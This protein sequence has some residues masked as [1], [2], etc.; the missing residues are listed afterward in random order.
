MTSHRKHH[1]PK[2]PEKEAGPAPEAP[3]PEGRVETVEI[4]KKELE[5]L[6]TLAG[7]D[8]EYR[9]R[10]LRTL[11][12]MENLRKRLERE[13]KEYIEYANQELMGEFIP[14]LDNFYRALQSIPASEA[15]APLRE[16]VKMIFR[17]LED[18]LRKQ[19]L[20]EIEAEGKTFNPH[21]H[22]AV[23]VEET[24]RCP[25]DTVLEVI[26]KGYLFRG[27]LLRPA[28]VRVSR[29]QPGESRADE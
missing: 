15:T 9:D 2:K 13:R 25:E 4:P 22:E 1:H 7:A 11:A 28:E 23:Q 21:L 26:R 14:V 29:P 3:E 20:E 16:G 10:M 17:Q 12:E 27:R 6:R 8:S 5:E 24:D 19:G 18:V